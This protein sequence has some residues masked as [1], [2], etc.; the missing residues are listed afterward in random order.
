MGLARHLPGAAG[1]DSALMLCGA[2]AVHAAV[3]QREAGAF[4]RQAPT[5]AIVLCLFSV[6]NLSLPN[7]TLLHL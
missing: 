1:C 6:Q 5:V 7:F 4:P 2:G 3:S